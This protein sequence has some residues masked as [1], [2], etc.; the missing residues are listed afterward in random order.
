MKIGYGL[1]AK[2]ALNRITGMP[3]LDSDMGFLAIAQEALTR[4]G[5]KWE[6]SKSLS[7][8]PAGST[9]IPADDE[10]VICERFNRQIGTETYSLKTVKV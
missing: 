6:P 8:Y 7:Q 9:Q 3:M 5:I 10:L 2:A 4:L 1:Y